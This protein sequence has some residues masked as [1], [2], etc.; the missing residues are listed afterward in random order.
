[1]YF[2]QL[3]LNKKGIQ[4]GFFFLC[5]ISRFLSLVIKNC[6]LF[7]IL[8]LRRKGFCRTLHRIFG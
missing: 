1:M 2:V 6:I 5:L 3:L 8:L 4:F 7:P